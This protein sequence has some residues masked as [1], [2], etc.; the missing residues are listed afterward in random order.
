M[1][2]TKLIVV[3][4]A[5]GNQGGSVADVFLSTPGW[6]VRALT[7]NPSS[8]KAKALASRGAEVVAADM[9][10]PS[11]LEP[12]L[13]GANAVFLVSD[14]WG[15]YGDPANKDKAKPGQPLNVWAAD[16]E[17]QQLKNVID[18]VAKLPTLERFVYS[19]LSNATRWSFGKYTHVYHFDSKARAEDYARETYPELWAKTSIF[20][21]GWF[22]SNFIVN[23]ILEFVKG[24]DGVARFTGNLD[25]DVKFPFI[26]AE[27]DSGPFV[28]ALVEE[29]AGK[30]VIAYRE[31]LTIREVA[32]ILSQVIGIP[33]EAVQLPKGQSKVTEPA[34]LKLELD[35][36]FAYWS[37]Y[38]YEGRAD[39][40]IIHPKDLPTLG[41]LDTVFDYF[42]KQ[43]WT[44]LKA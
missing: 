10:V 38:G 41:K 36:N 14:F 21:A 29:P 43:D 23:P 30:N 34:E 42:K 24:D 27:E 16:H 15:L 13:Q 37:E 9:D 8:A 22:L 18:I 12:A 1:A 5:T 3:V 11:T 28:K 20:Q 33:T 40:T 19:S 44:K 31:W 26:A 39:P 17:V 4:G 7:R 32:A 35:D 6:R 25:V 2:S